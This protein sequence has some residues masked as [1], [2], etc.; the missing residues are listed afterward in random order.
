MVLALAA[1]VALAVLAA[2]PRVRAWEDRLGLGFVATTGVPFLLL[3]AF[4]AAPGVEV[5]H[6]GLLADLRP[7]FDFALGW[8]GF[9]VGA[10]LEVRRL[11]ALP[12]TFPSAVALTAIV[13][14]LVTAAVGAPVLLGL[15]L[16]SGNGLVRDLIVLAAS[17]AASGSARARGPSASLRAVTDVD[18]TASLVLLAMVTIWFRPEVS[19]AQWVM[20]P[21]GWL[22]AL[23]GLGTLLGVLTHLLLRGAHD[24]AEQ[25]ALLVG[26]VALSAGIAGYLALS[27]PVVCALAGA[28][29]VNLPIRQGD[30][31]ASALAWVERPLYSMLLM[32]V[33]AAWDPWGWEGIALAVAFA[34][35][36]IGGKLL[37]TYLASRLGAL[38]DDRRLI[39]STLLPQSPIAVV[40]IVAAA[41]TWSGDVPAAAQ[42]AITAVIVGSLVAELA[43]RLFVREVAR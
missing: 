14:M 28:T 10:R 32:V 22:L 33:G 2:N 34:V 37:G 43:T 23:L 8:I 18:E 12:A 4:Y 29:L 5:L 19:G 24:D 38:P 9:S 26:A 41:A 31:L 1:T 21:S 6:D 42:W 36:R 35:G 13:P 3:G 25:V 7:A 30:R 27:V 11:E 17:A 20:P 39:A 40:V 16:T 15:G